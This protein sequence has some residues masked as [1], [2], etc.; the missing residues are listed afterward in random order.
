[1]PNNSL[2][3]EIFNGHIAAV[4]IAA[5][6]ELGLFDEL[7]K[8]GFVHLP[9]YAG[10][11]Q[12]HGM[13]LD[14]IVDVLVLYGIFTKPADGTTRPGEGF[15]DVFQNKGYFTWL[16]S[17]YG[18]MF[19]RFSAITRQENRTPGFI[20]RDGRA[21]ALGGRD[22]GKQYVDETF[23]RVLQM[24]PFRVI[25]DLGCGSAERIMGFVR[26][27]GGQAVGIDLNPGA[28]ELATRLV[29]EAGL[30]DRVQLVRSDMRELEPSPLLDRVDVLTSFFNGHDLW[31]RAECLQVLKRLKLVFRNASRFL[32]CDTYRG[33]AFDAI[34]RV[35][36][37]TLGFEVTH[38]AMDQYIPTREEWLDLLTESGWVCH[39][40]HEIGIPF[41]A[42]FDLSPA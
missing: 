26:H 4:A 1:M 10:K 2:A 6:N 16:T 11:N 22:Y 42:I 12:L 31:P 24:K 18:R 39:G 19:Q 29:S 17:G 34:S 28:I 38:A 40:V 3:A 32:L 33:D 23:E 15:R 25:G 35:P 30:A 13:T 41:S 37:F 5:A 14:S 7:D 36:I 21:I 8:A 27:F 20:E 9:S